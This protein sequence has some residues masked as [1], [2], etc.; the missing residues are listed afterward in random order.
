MDGYLVLVEQRTAPATIDA[1]ALD[2]YLVVVEPPDP[3]ATHAL[4]TGTIDAHELANLLASMGQEYSEPELRVLLE[5]VRDDVARSFP[6]RPPNDVAHAFPSE[7]AL[8]T[9]LPH[10]ETRRCA[11]GSSAAAST[12]QDASRTVLESTR[13]EAFKNRAAGISAR[14][15]R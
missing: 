5:T 3:Y 6:S 13:A 7:P 8:P 10:R 9:P 15:C 2:G 4:S 14:G 1:R 12:S 11:V